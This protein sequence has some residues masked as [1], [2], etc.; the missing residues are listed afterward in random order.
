MSIRMEKTQIHKHLKQNENQSNSKIGNVQTLKTL[1]QKNRTNSNHHNRSEIQ[2]AS[3]KRFYGQHQS[4]TG[5]NAECCTHYSYKTGI[6]RCSQ[7]IQHLNN[8][9]LPNSHQTELIQE[10]EICT[11]NERFNVPFTFELVEFLADCWFWMIMN[12][13]YGLFRT[14]CARVNDTAKA[15]QLSEFFVHSLRCNPTTQ[16]L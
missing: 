11:Q 5:R 15:L 12:T 9:R 16:P 14:R 13:F 6:D 2:F 8:V 3:S 10:V 7:S 4:E 1:T